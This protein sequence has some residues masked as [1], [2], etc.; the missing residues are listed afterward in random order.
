MKKVKF[1]VKRKRHYRIHNDLSN[2]AFHF[3]KELE[4]MLQDNDERGIT[5]VCMSCL[6][7]LAFAVEAKINFVGEKCVED[8]VEREAFKK[9]LKKV[10][11]TLKINLDEGH[12]RKTVY[13]LQS[14]RDDVAHGKPLTLEDTY[15]V[16][17]LEDEEHIPEDLAPKWL[18][19]CTAEKTIHIYDEINSFLQLLLERSE[20]KTFDASSNGQYEIGLLEIVEK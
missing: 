12:I 19:I 16:I 1:E 17:V 6:M 13:L 15:E 14:C 10:C 7:M 20:I 11:K 8:W 5:F 3:K 9:K 2:G 4:R 18:E